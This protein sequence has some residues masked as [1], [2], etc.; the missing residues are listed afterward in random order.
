MQVIIG[1]LQ[2]EVHL[3]VRINPFRLYLVVTAL[4][5]DR[6]QLAG[7]KVTPQSR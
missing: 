1:R 7:A 2:H 5:P 4:G 3:Y 6:M